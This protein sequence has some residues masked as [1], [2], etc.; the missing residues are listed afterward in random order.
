MAARK[1]RPKRIGVLCSGGDCSGMNPAVRAVVRAALYYKMEPYGIYHGYQGL[2]ENEIRALGSRDVSGIENRGGTIFGSSRSKAFR[3]KRGRKRAIANLTAE[4]ITGLIVIGGDGSFH[5]AEKLHKES[6]LC[7]VGVPGTIDNDLSGTDFT[8]GYSTAVN[9]ALDAVDKIRDTAASHERI[10][11]VEVMGRH[12]GYIA[13]EVG[14]AG[15]AEEVLIPETAT[16][17]KGLARLLIEGRKRG[18]TSSIVLVAEGDEEGGALTIAKKVGRHANLP[19]RV[20]ILGHLQRGGTP[21]AEDRLLAS[22][23][24]LAAV[25]QLRQGRSNI[26]VGVLQGRVQSRALRTSWSGGKKVTQELLDLVRILSL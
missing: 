6:D 2:I 20:S 24:G 15:G 14:I 1:K 3:T 10:F 19:V 7:V 25:R 9:V 11:F 4:G 21:S 13:L 23:L 16:D 5:G 12:A 26:M 22:R 8:I 18:K 17:I